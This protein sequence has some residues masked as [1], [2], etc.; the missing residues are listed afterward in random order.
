M[1]KFW[2][3]IAT[4]LFL[5]CVVGCKSG[6][7]DPNNVPEG[8]WLYSMNFVFEVGDNHED[9]LLEDYLGRLPRTLIGDAGQVYY[10]YSIYLWPSM[11]EQIG[12][13]EEPYR[14]LLESWLPDVGTEEGYQERFANRFCEYYG[15]TDWLKPEDCLSSTVRICLRSQEMMP[16]V[17]DEMLELLETPMVGWCDFVYV[18]NYP[19]TPNKV[20]Y[21]A[22]LQSG[23]LPRE[24]G[25]L[26]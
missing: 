18:T 8:S 19:R 20:L 10:E 17:I 16:E 1:K 6:P 13:L 2:I 22:A 3:V 7:V 26:A 5:L 15:L 11:M 21:G 25:V 24:E 14:S 9:L 4:A 12:E 23:K